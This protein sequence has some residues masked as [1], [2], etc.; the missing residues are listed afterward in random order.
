MKVILADIVKISHLKA[1][2]R[3]WTSY[4]TSS[5]GFWKDYWPSPY[6]SGCTQP[7]STSSGTT[8]Y[9]C[10]TNSSDGYN[11]GAVWTTTSLGPL[12]NAGD[13]FEANVQTNKNYISSSEYMEMAVFASDHYNST[14]GKCGGS[15][16]DN[17]YG[18][19]M[20]EQNNNS[21]ADLYYQGYD[22]AT[23]TNLSTTYFYENT[24]N[25]LTTLQSVTGEFDYSTPYPYLY[26]WLGG[27]QYNMGIN[28]QLKSQSCF[29]IGW[30]SQ[31]ESNPLSN[32]NWY[33]F[34]NYVFLTEG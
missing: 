27:V 34:S 24:P 32:P 19:V 14:T 29:D 6:P 2:Q 18:I 17:E 20:N 10:Y 26:M 30:N 8:F 9:S 31:P 23:G 25:P 16:G 3:G 4:M 28:L 13:G 11:T 7:Q 33:L 12:S 22:P 15:K 5:T 1:F 21:M